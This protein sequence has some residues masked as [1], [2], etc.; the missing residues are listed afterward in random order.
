MTKDS[1]QKK[2]SP[3]ARKTVKFIIGIILLV[4][5]VAAVVFW[6]PEVISLIKGCLGLVL[7]GLGA[8]AII[9]SK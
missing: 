9:I 3:A 6:W 4:L 5:G 1:C 8:I 2:I 7:I